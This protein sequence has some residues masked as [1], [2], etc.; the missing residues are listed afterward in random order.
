MND[1]L[2][3]PNFVKNRARTYV[4]LKKAACK[5]YAAFFVRIARIIFVFFAILRGGFFSKSVCVIYV[6]L[7]TGTI[8]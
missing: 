5:K 7:L 1:I 6:E 3:C 8:I 4:L 2:K